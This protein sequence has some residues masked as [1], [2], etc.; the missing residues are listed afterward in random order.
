MDIPYGW[1]FCTAP[2]FLLSYIY[3]LLYKRAE[4][5]DLCWSVSILINA[6]VLTISYQAYGPRTYILLIG[7]G[8]WAF[9]LCYYLYKTR[10]KAPHEDPRYNKLRENWGKS[11]QRNFLI[12][13]IGQWALSVI[14]SVTFIPIIA[15]QLSVQISDI[16]GAVIFVSGIIGESIA[17]GTLREYVSRAENRGTICEVGVW[18]YSRHPNYF[19]EWMMWLS[20]PLYAIGADWWALSLIG[21]CIMYL[22]LRY[23]TGV[24]PLEKRMRASRGVVFDE[25]AMRVSEFWPRFPKAKV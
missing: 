8:L 4:I 19:F 5:V 15:N 13:F 23:V 2:L 17:D 7:L 25:Y 22:L 1:V 6:V 24:P 10:I 14:L 21:P 3:Q 20:Y 16:L 11:A 18:R 12:L 9:R